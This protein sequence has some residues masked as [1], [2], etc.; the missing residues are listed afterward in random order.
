[1]KEGEAERLRPLIS[2][3]IFQIGEKLPVERKAM[4]I[5]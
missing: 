3:A 1:M 4:L 5:K 2:G